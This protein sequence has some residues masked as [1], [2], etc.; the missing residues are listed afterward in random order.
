[1]TARAVSTVLDV[2][3]CVLLVGAAVLT[4]VSATAPEPD[5]AAGRAEEV[6]TTL[7][8][9][10]ATVSYASGDE[11]RTA[12]GTLA[13]LLADAAVSNRTPSSG[14]GLRDAV[15]NATRPAL[16]GRGW[17]AEVVA[18]WRPYE[19][20]EEV[21]RIRV[22]GRP[23]AG[24]DV[25]AATMIVP[26]GVDPVREAALYAAERGGFDGVANVVTASIDQP[27]DGSRQASIVRSD[28][29]STYESPDEAARAVTVGSVH[30][31]VRTWS[32]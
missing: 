16:V 1:M 27:G 6:A 21:S 10:T 29:E 23:P 2:C 31:V 32:T 28:L 5:P 17:R 12:H 22:G 8:G 20:A 25:H 30:V 26:S 9:A 19:G 24:V 7:A 18:T 15:G 13:G 4:L 3:L 14:R 11:V